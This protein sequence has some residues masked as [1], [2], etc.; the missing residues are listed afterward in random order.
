[1]KNI[2]AATLT[3]L[4]ICVGFY[5]VNLDSDSEFERWAL[6]HG[7]RYFG[8]EKTYRQSIYFQNKQMID[9]HNKRTDVTYLMGENQFMAITNEEF[10]G[11]YL[12]PLS[13]EKQN[14]QDQII[15]KTNP[16][17]PEPKIEQNLKEEYDWRGYAPV[18]DTGNCASSW[19]MA[20]TNA[21]EAQYAIVKGIKVTLSA[22]NVIDCDGDWVG[23]DGIPT[24]FTQPQQAYEHART[25]GILTESEYPYVGRRD[26]YSCQ[27]SQ[28]APWKILSYMQNN[29]DID[30]MRGFLQILR[31]QPLSVRVDATNWQFYSSGVFSLCSSLYKNSNY[32]ALA[33]GYD[34][35]NKNWRVQAS[36]GKSWG[37]FGTIRLAP[38]NTCGL[39]N[40]GVFVTLL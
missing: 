37:E 3:S 39:I 14:E 24:V 6:K 9:E 16:K 19:A 31:V 23:C 21:I 12:N 4:L 33:I 1:M 26:Y 18:K 29:D 27:Q 28:L 5:Q 11:L 22:Q 32:F 40:E 38:G 36:F 34:Y 7:K 10:V 17:S 20:A 2:I 25:R 8:D 35:S 15:T 30:Y 13:P